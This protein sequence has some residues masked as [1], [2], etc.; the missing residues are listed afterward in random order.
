MTFHYLTR[1]THRPGDLD[2]GELALGV[3]HD[4][5][6]DVSLR[7]RP[8]Q[9]QQQRRPFFHKSDSSINFMKGGW[10]ERDR[11]KAGPIGRARNEARPK[12]SE[13]LT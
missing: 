6:D 9:R 10:N 8:Q 4:P 12:V 13:F 7:P 3:K 1:R 5:R 11:P 2:E